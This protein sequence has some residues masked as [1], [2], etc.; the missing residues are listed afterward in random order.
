MALSAY[1]LKAIMPQWELLDIYKGM[2]PYMALQA[3]AVL[4]L[5]LFPQIVMWL[6]TLL[7]G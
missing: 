6:P 5:A 4:L 2:M 7:F 3:V 1:Y